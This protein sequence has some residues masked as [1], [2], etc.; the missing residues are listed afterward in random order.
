VRKVSEE[1]LIRLWGRAVLQMRLNNV[2]AY[3]PSRH[4]NN[5]THIQC[6]AEAT[7]TREGVGIMPPYRRSRYTRREHGQR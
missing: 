4:N 2:A 7:V 1:H 5:D 6:R 3:L